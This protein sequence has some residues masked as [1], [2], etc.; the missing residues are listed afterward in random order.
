MACVSFGFFM[1]QV[2][3]DAKAHSFS[4]WKGNVFSVLPYSK[5]IRYT[6]VASFPTTHHDPRLANKCTFHYTKNSDILF[7]VIIG[8][9][10]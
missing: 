3:G 5:H 10:L 9:A 7:A 8:N 2:P 1:K 6:L 4:S